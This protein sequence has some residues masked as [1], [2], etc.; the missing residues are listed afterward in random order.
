M[1]CWMPD[2]DG[3]D[4]TRELRRHEGPTVHVPVIALTADVLADARGRCLEAGMDDYLAKPMHL[5]ELAALLQ[6]WAPLP[7]TLIASEPATEAPAVAPSEPAVGA[8]SAVAALPADP[9]AEVC[10]L[11]P[12]VLASFRVA[13]DVDTAELLQTLVQQLRAE[14]PGRLLALG[15]ALAQ[16]DGATLARVAHLL[17]AQAATVGLREVAA[18]AAQLESNGRAPDLAAAAATA[19]ALAGAWARANTILDVLLTG[20]VRSSG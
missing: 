14:V 20:Q 9:P 6:R 3:F 7:G 15:D 1:D 17:A 13:T 11:D 12:E 5:E 2:L 18:L 4:A 8:V 16:G 19:D 10:V